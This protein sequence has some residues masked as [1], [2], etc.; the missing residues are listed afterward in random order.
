MHPEAKKMLSFV[1]PD[2]TIGTNHNIN[3]IMGIL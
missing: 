3:E 1:K 2:E